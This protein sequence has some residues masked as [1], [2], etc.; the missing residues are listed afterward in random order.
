METSPLSMNPTDGGRRSWNALGLAAL[1]LVC[2]AAPSVASHRQ[3]PA[4]THHAIQ[5]HPH[6]PPARAVA[7][8]PRIAHSPTVVKRVPP[9]KSAPPPANIQPLVFAP[10]PVFHVPAPSVPPATYGGG[11]GNV[12]PQIGGSFGGPPAQGGSFGGGRRT[13]GSFGNGSP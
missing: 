7:R 5:T 12:G 4:L 11:G 6:R 8:R 2:I 10:S 13:G 9:Q 3:K 1:C